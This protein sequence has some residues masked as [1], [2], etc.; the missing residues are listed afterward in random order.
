MPNE[1]YWRFGASTTQRLVRLGDKSSNARTKNVYTVKEVQPF[2]M[3][4]QTAHTESV[5]RI[6][7]LKG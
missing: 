1:L 3:F 4:P 6:E 7:R 5:V 2:D